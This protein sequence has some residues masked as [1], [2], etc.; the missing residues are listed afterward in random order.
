MCNYEQNKQRGFIKS[1]RSML[2][3]RWFR[4]PNTSH[5]FMT[6]LLLANHEDKKWG[7]KIVKR[8]EL[9]TSVQH[10]AEYSGLT[11]KQ[12]RTGLKN[13]KNTNEIIVKT[14]NKYTAISIVNYDS[15]QNIEEKGQT[16]DKQMATNKND[17]NDKN[18]SNTL[19]TNTLIIRTFKKPTIEEIKQYCIER[20]NQIDAEKFY[21]YY[22]S[23]GWKVGK[24][25]MKNW[26]AAVRTWE[27]NKNDKCAKTENTT[28]TFTPK[29]TFV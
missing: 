8:G 5:L 10:L 2:D 22:E 29:L 28:I 11:I 14:T 16:N 6:L 19:N 26:K 24:N 4:F 15:Y 9:I 23:N 21:D 25:S 17:K 18:N 7:E 20:N 12:V 13:L 27:K 1:F 3:W